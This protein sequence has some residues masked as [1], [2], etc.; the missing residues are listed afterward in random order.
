M[1]THSRILARGIPWTEASGRIQSIVSQRV[2][3]DLAA[4][5]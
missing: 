3:H 5:Q 1:A 4:K 2:G